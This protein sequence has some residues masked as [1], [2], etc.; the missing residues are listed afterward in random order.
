MDQP[1]N[2]LGYGSDL[3]AQI[4]LHFTVNE[5]DLSMLDKELNRVIEPGD[6][7]LMIGR[8]CKDIRL[9]TTLTINHPMTLETNH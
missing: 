3:V 1:H 7:R 5:K 9:K 2:W 4:E 6:F 8:S